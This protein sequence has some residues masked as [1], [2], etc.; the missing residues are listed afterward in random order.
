[1]SDLSYDVL[2]FSIG[3]VTGLFGCIILF[4]CPKTSTKSDINEMFSFDAT[5]NNLN[6]NNNKF[7][8][9]NISGYLWYSEK[10]NNA[11]NSNCYPEKKIFGMLYTNNK[12]VQYTEMTKENKPSG[13]WDDYKLLGYGRWIRNENY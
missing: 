2:M 7:H 10:Q 11:S 1:M 4:G 12:I 13:K 6:Y 8:A 5:L 9:N 3:Y